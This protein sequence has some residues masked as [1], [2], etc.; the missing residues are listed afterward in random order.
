MNSLGRRSPT[1]QGSV[2]SGRSY[3]SRLLPRPAWLLALTLGL[4]SPASAQAPG[5]WAPTADLNQPRA[6]H[7]ATLLASGTVLI[8]G[9]RDAADQPLASAEIY[10]PAT[11]GYTLLASPLPAPVWGH[12]ATRLDDGTVLIAGGQRGARYR[13]AAQ[14][15]D[16]ATDTFAALTPMST[17]RGRHT[18]TLLRDGRVVVIGGTDGV[19]PLAS[20]EI[21]DPTTRTFALAPGAVEGARQ[22]HP[23]T[24]L[25]DGR[26]LVAGGS[27]ASGALESA[28]L[29]DPTAGTVSPA[30]PL[31]VPRTLASAALLL[32]GTVLVA[33]GQ[34][35]TSEDLDS[36]EIYD[37]ATN[38]FAWLPAAMGTARSG[39]LGVQLLHNVKVLISGGTSGGQLVASAE[40]YDPVTGAFQPGDSPGTAR[41]L[42]GANF[43]ELPYTGILL[44]TGGLDS[45]EAPLA[46]SE[47]F[48]YPTL[49]S[50]K[51]DYAP[52]ETVTLMGEGWRPNEQVAINI[53]ESSGDP[54]TNL[55]ATA[56]T[57]GAFTNSEFQ[58]NPDRS[59]VGVRFLATATG[60]SS[61]WTAQTTFS[62]TAQF[63]ATINPTSATVNTA[64]TYTLTVTNTS[65][66][67]EVM[68]CVRVTIPAGAG[69]PGSLSVVAT[70]P[71]PTTRTWNT[72]TTS[73][74][75]ITTTRSG[76]SAN[77]IDPGGTVAI[78]FTATATTTGTKTWTTSAFGATNCTGTPFSISGGSGSQPSVNVTPT[79]AINDVS[80]NEGNSGT[81]PFVFTVSLSNASSQTITVDFAT[82]D[83]TA[84]VAD[85]D[86]VAASGTVTFAPGVTSQPVTVTVNGDTKFESNETFFVN[87]SNPTGGATISDGQGQ[88][89]IVNDDT[90]PTLAIDDVSQAEGSTGGTTA[91]TFTVTKT[92]ATAQSVTVGFTTVDG[93]ATGNSSCAA[94][95]TGTPDYISQTGTLTFAPSDPSKTITV[96]VCADTTFQLRQAFPARRSADPGATISDGQGQG[97]IVNDDTAP[98]LAI[99]D[100]SQAEGS[101]GGTT[102]FT[103]TVTKTGATAQSVT[104]GFTT[105]D[106]TATGNSSCAAA[107]TGTPDYIS[108]TGTLTFAPSDPS[109]TITVQ[110]CA[111]TTFE[112]SE[113]STVKL[114]GA[115][116]AT[117]TKDTGIGTIVNDDA[118][119]PAD[120]AIT[121]SAPGLA[122]SGTDINYHLTVTNNGLT[123]STGGT[124]TDILP[125]QVSFKSASAGCAFT[126]PSTV[127]CSFGPLATNLSVSFDI[128]VHISVAATGTMTNT[129]NVRGSEAETNQA[130]NTDTATTVVSPQTTPGK[131]TGG[132]VINVNG[133]TANFGFVAQRKTTGGPASG[134]LNYLDHATKRHVQGPVTSLTITGNSAEFSGPCGSSCTF[135]VSVQDKGE[136][137]AGKDM[138]YIT[139]NSPAYA[140]GGVIRSGNIQV[141]NESPAPAQRETVATGAGEGIFPS[142]AAL[143]GIL[144]NGLQFGKGVD[145]PGDG[146][147]TGDF[148]ALLLGTSLLGQP[149]KINIVGQ[150]SSGSV[151]PDG[152]AIFAGLSTVDMGDGTAPLTGVPCSVTATTQGLRLILGNTSLPAATLT[153]GRITIQ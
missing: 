30:G 87:L 127:S 133:G 98:T 64:T 131:V 141:H 39:H 21:Y 105:V 106:G 61:R 10:D 40:V 115:T 113:A 68:D 69:T 37:A 142:G 146:S 145:I 41:R 59:D 6:E 117:I 3:L 88:G 63:T 150:A 26:V 110:V 99:D 95:G 82:A 116:G 74:G 27:N 34:T 60:Q 47:V 24:L 124:V 76:G 81:T 42:F 9:G 108:Q 100:V 77:S 96:Q 73:G 151:N 57:S 50:D 38:T 138:F 102:A 19:G 143:N 121:K 14:L 84:T 1:M 25:P 130:N 16:P 48:F 137:G 147:A 104:V 111:D 46:S 93:T 120:L 33:G 79:L 35:T 126:A 56:D 153:A 90:A 92:G 53:R 51:S 152:S 22:D 70:D 20:L 32:D 28:E 18:A 119:P 103:F 45:A 107:A 72:P 122:T 78:S 58:T 144:L 118:L 11:G 5:T 49:R 75:V 97:T 65:T 149:Q 67:M 112:L 123:P 139:V 7:T 86:Y 148:Q 71:G 135:Y 54:D 55:T 114:S 80:Q 136:P 29:Y 8:A 12:T 94:A 140:A 2:S 134:N 101:T 4:A 128:T 15:F 43:F 17:P 129:A 89:T 132:G 44:A 125:A 23:A 109:K 52:G 85:N 66:A 91:F 31:N 83:D 13:R 36:A 62:D